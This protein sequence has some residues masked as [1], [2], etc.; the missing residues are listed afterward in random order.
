MGS[1]PWSVLLQVTVLAAAAA[2]AAPLPFTKIT[3]NASNTLCGFC[4]PPGGV[5]GQDNDTFALLD[6]Q[7]LAGDPAHDDHA[8]HKIKFSSIWM[9]GWQRWIYPQVF[10]LVDLGRDFNFEAVYASH[11]SGQVQMQWTVGVDPW[12]PS[13]QWAVNTTAGTDCVGWGWSDQWCGWNM[14]TIVGK[15]TVAARYITIRM[16]NPATIGEIVVYGTPAVAAAVLDKP[17][18]LP[19]GL[20]GRNAASLRA[21][22]RTRGKTVGSKYEG[23]SHSPRQ[24]PLWRTFVGTNAFVTDPLE[25]LVAVGSVREYHDWQ[26]TEPAGDPGFPHALNMYNPSQPSFKFDEFYNATFD[27][28]LSLHQCLQ[29]RAIFLDG[30]NHNKSQSKWKPLPDADFGAAQTPAS[31]IAL[32]AHG[33]QTAA[34]YGRNKVADSALQLAKGQPRVSGLGTLSYMETM[35]EPDGD[36][37]DGLHQY[38]QPFELAAMHSAVFDGHE[39]TL[40]AGVGILNAD[41][42]MKVV[43][44]GLAHFQNAVDTVKEIALWAQHHRKDKSFPAH[45]I[46]VHKYCFNDQQTA[47]PALGPEECYDDPEIRRLVAWRNNEAPDLAVWM[48]EFGW[49][50]SPHS[51][52]RVAVYGAHGADEVQAM[53]IARAFVILAGQRLERVHQFMLH[54]VVEGG[55][56]QF[57]TSGMTTSPDTDP[58]FAPKISWY[59]VHTLVALLG[60]MRLV[61]FTRGNAAGTLPYIAVFS[62][63]NGGGGNGD[64]DGGD[65]DRNGDGDGTTAAVDATVVWLASA[66][67][68]TLQWSL[69]V[70]K[71]APAATLKLVQLVDNSTVGL[72]SAATATAGGKLTLTVHETPQLILVG[73][74][75]PIPPSGPVPPIT[76]APSAACAPYKSLRERGLFCTNTS[77]TSTASTYLVCPSGATEICPDGE[78]CASGASAGTVSC[79]PQSGPCEGKGPG[80]YCDPAVPTPK[81]WPESYTLCPQVRTMLCPTKTPTCMQENATVKCA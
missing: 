2:L 6:E 15:P 28:G 78:R 32:A 16:I 73:G 76:P 17:H 25:R 54:D 62:S 42:S 50:T 22:A 27:A 80:L 21:K 53:W 59:Y 24:A 60:H 74:G 13:A 47:T 38:M 66:A 65:G 14:S 61:N 43:M 55:W 77:A 39:K 34:R 8:T 3:L 81:G 48:T 19:V 9:A 52:N 11:G 7:V 10:A 30:P 33:F 63:G 5:A 44:S 71:N 70:K 72:Q 69:P 26:W 46:N 57:A 56:T 35:N 64:G 41:P 37:P 40:G 31:Y 1:V 20:A 12:T 58:P 51:P 75:P 36:Y 68:K 45:V 23:R 29:G 67:D 79:V 18:D 4:D 49:D